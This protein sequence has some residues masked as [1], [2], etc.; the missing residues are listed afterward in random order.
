MN[1]KKISF[2]KFILK[3]LFGRKLLLYKK[4]KEPDMSCLLKTY[5]H[6]STNEKLFVSRL[7]SEIY[8]VTNYGNSRWKGVVNHCLEFEG[9]CLFIRN[10]PPALLAE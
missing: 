3:K 8:G 9:A 4:K 6:L 1:A 2:V 5:C 10:L 7:F